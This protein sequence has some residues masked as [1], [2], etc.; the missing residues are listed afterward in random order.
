MKDQEVI[1]LIQQHP[2]GCIS[3]EC[4]ESQAAMLEAALL[5]H[6]KQLGILSLEDGL[7]PHMRVRQYLMIF[8]ELACKKNL[9]QEAVDQMH[10]QD[11]L[12]VKIEKLSVS[13]K[14]RVIAAREIIHDQPTLLLRE[15]LRYLE[16]DDVRVMLYWIEQ[17]EKFHK[18]VIITSH[19]LKDV[20]MMPG[21]HYLLDAQKQL[22]RIEN[23][24]NQEDIVQP[25]KISARLDEKILLFNPNEIDYIESMDGKSYLY[26]RGASF[27]CS[28]TMEELEAKLKRFGFYR[29]HR[30]YLVN[31]QKVSEIV[32]W[33]RNSYT[34]KL[35]DLADA[36]IPL[37]KGRVEEMK[38][39]YDF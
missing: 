24:S 32:K 33:T 14:I 16:E 35:H 31:M 10:L 34:L 25:L 15:P 3:F 38:E 18:R 26:V 4:K 8:A 1:S 9:F 17:Q 11:L 39:L 21:E 22:Q 12:H 23:I 30:S 13:Q 7:Y 27:I 19:S 5:Q 2:S 36:R 29:S 28:M 37:S 6:T 20:C